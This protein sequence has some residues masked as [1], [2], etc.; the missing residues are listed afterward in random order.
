MMYLAQFEFPCSRDPHEDLVQLQTALNARAPECVV[1]LFNTSKLLPPKLVVSM[2]MSSFAAVR[3]YLAI[4]QIGVPH[5]MELHPEDG[6]G[7]N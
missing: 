7:P 5:P 4:W 6:G 1:Q 3:D 2:P